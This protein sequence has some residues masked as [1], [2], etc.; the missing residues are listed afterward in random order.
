MLRWIQQFRQNKIALARAGFFVV[1]FLF[2]CIIFFTPGSALAQGSLGLETFGRTTILSGENLIVIV[3]RIINAALGLL[4]IITVG[5]ILYAGYLI[6]TAGGD[7]QKVAEGKLFLRNAVI[8]L[9][10]ILSAFAIVQFVLSR[11]GAA[12]GIQSFLGGRGRQTTIGDFSNSGAL[13]ESIRDH[14]PFRNETGVRRNTRIAV[15]FAEPIRAESFIAN[16][17]GNEVIGDCLDTGTAP[18]NW[19]I[20]CD[21]LNTDVVRIHPTD[22]E[23]AVIPAAVLAVPGG[24]NGEIAAVVFRPL[25]L[26]GSDTEE[27]SYTVELTEE[28]RRA[29]GESSIFSSDLDGRYIWEFETATTIDTEPPTVESVYPAPNDTVARNSIIQINFSEAVDPSVV[30]GSI[31]A[32]SS[33]SQ[34]VFGNAAVAGEWRVTN[35]YQTAEFV[36]NDPCGQNSCGEEMYC[37]PV[38]PDVLILLRTARLISADSFESV[39]LTG[40]AD[41]AGNALDG[42]GDGIPDGKPDVPLDQHIAAGGEDTPDN[43]AWDFV[44]ENTIDRTAPYVRTVS[45]GI[46]AEDTPVDAD[47]SI[48]FSNRMWGATFSG[49]AIVPHEPGDEPIPFWERARMEQSPDGLMTTAHLDHREF[50]DGLDE[51]GNSLSSFYFPT[52][53]STVKNVTQNCLYPGR[54]PAPIDPTCIYEEDI[55]GNPLPGTGA[56]CAP[57][58][59]VDRDHDTG[60]VYGTT[61]NPENWE[62]AT[63]DG[64]IQRLQDVSPLP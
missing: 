18:L 46:D 30:Q 1:C 35:A 45:P 20:D 64:C 6:M 16:T 10:I 42:D 56:N 21:Q 14:Y 5:L 63:M 27:I 37:L 12:T 54:G 17:N 15:T 41:M 8:G 55:D 29:D 60:C 52:V 59:S 43:Y 23:S 47:V 28:I 49:I 34:I 50:L 58:V 4:G 33:F 24:P 26:L 40:V 57:G 19:A 51:E 7:E 2:L 22:D 62:A 13:G 53:S 3:V 36:S 39:P 38:D 9:A 11:L 61:P 48:A 25:D 31:G 44:I 32:G